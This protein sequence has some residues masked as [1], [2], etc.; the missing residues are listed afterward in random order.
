MVDFP[1][2]FGPKNPII[3]PFLAEKLISFNAN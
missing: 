2:P 3:S 1:A